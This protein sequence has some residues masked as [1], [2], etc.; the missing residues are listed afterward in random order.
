MLSRARRLLAI[1]L[2]A[3]FSASPAFAEADTPEERYNDAFAALLRGD[4]DRARSG[5]EAV[6]RL[7]PSHEL[8]AEASHW[9]GELALARRDNAGAATAFSTTVRRYPDS[10]RAAESF[11][12]LG[13]AQARMGD[14]A[15]ACRTF[16]RFSGAYPD[17]SASLTQRVANEASRS[18]CGRR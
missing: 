14:R 12:R 7:H 11:F 9:L 5:F 16:A 6:L 15:V 2:L 13:V 17:A 4:D 10:E 8:A 18:G 3:I 1:T